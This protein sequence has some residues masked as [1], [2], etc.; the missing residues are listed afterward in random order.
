M[1]EKDELRKSLIAK[2]DALAPNEWT[3][4]SSKIQKTVLESKLYNECDKLFI[5]S[6]FHGEVGTLM[7][8]EDA[9]MRDKEVYLPKCL[10][11]FTEARM[12]FYRVRSTY[13]LVSGYKG[14]LEPMDNPEN[15]F[16][17]ENDSDGNLLMF[18]PGVVFDNNHNRMGYGKGYYDNY[19][20]NKDN[21]F[22]IGIAFSLQIVDQIPITE[23]DIKMD[24][25]VTENTTIDE[26]NKCT[27]KG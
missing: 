20:K 19:L 8:I 17:Y 15:C 1:V 27:Y 18:V 2:R 9:L 16:N 6:D 11:N 21:I 24:F 26:I 12:D 23:N 13:E 14:I 5:Y 4:A 7:I 10:E 22:K 25:V 3:G